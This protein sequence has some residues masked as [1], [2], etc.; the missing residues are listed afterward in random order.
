ME[1]PTELTPQNMG[2]LIRAVHAGSGPRRMAMEMQGQN[3]KPAVFDVQVKAWKPRKV[4]TIARFS[5]L[6]DAR[7]CVA[8]LTALGFEAI[9]TYEDQPTKDTEQEPTR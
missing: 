4:V 6:E 3:V 1:T 2:D 9:L 8:G 5:T 7:D